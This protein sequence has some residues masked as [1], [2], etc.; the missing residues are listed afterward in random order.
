MYPDKG[1][2]GNKLFA[3]LRQST[4]LL[5]IVVD[6]SNEP[7]RYPLELQK[8]VQFLNVASQVMLRNRRVLHNWQCVCV[9]LASYRANVCSPIRDSMLSL[10]REVM[11]FVDYEDMEIVR[12]RQKQ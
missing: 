1:L 11:C 8:Y 6:P 7:A 2:I 12:E 3:A 9:L 5:N 10:M 4:S